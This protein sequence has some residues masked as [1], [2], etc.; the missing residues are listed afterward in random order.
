MG[1]AIFAFIVIF[2]LVGS[3]LLLLFYPECGQRLADALFTAGE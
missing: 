1:Y 3:G 2:L